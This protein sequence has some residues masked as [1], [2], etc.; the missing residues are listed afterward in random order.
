MFNFFKKYD[1]TFKV[2]GVKCEG[3]MHKIYKTLI[4]LD[5]VKKVETNFKKKTVYV[6]LVSK[7]NYDTKELVDAINN[8]GFIVKE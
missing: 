5:N 1:V 7:E 2:D 6:D 3:C 4:D 8:A